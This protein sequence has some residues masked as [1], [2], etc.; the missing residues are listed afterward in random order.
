[1][2]SAS[3]A[4]I[5]LPKVLSESPI[6]APTAFFAIDSGRVFAFVSV[7]DSLP[8]GE[9][10]SSRAAQL[11]AG[12]GAFPVTQR[13]TCLGPG[14]IGDIPAV[15]LANYAKIK[16]PPAT[17]HPK[18]AVSFLL[19]A[20]TAYIDPADGRVR[21][22]IRLGSS[23]GTPPDTVEETDR[24]FS[25]TLWD[26]YGRWM[27]HLSDTFRYEQTLQNPFAG[28][29][30]LRL[31]AV[32][33]DTVDGRPCFVV[34]YHAGAPDHEGTTKMYWVDLRDRVAVRVK[35]EQLTLRRIFSERAAFPPDP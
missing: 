18:R 6:P 31:E 2:G 30:T 33:R 28:V 35:Q 26:F 14:W 12:L 8:E 20:A 27:L 10:R 4:L 21:R 23:P 17:P 1:V 34:R 22:E 15:I 7:E 3:K 5:P 32:G 16:N 9:R 11:S 29:T 25:R 24:D 19:K 13:I